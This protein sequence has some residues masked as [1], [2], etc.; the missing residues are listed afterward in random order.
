MFL[1]SSENLALSGGPGGY[2][3]HSAFKGA[4][5]C[6]PNQCQNKQIFFSFLSFGAQINDFYVNGI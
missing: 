5:G 2:G 6:D 1:L 4:T 3:P